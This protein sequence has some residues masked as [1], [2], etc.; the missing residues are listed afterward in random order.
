MAAR[1]RMA[2]AP[3]RARTRPRSTARPPMPRATSPRTSSPPTSPT[4]APS[5]SPTRSASPSRCRSMSTCTAPA[6]SRRAGS[7]RRSSDV[8]DLSPRGIREHLG[9]NRPIYARTSA[10]GHFGRAPEAD[11]GFSWEK[12]DL[13]DDAPR[14][15]ALI[16]GYPPSERGARPWRRSTAEPARPAEGQAPFGATRPALMADRLA[17]ARARHRRAAASDLSRRSFRFRSRTC[18]SR[19]ASAAA[20]ISSPRRSAAPDTGFI[21]VEPF[22][23]RHGEGG[24]RRSTT[25]DSGTSASTTATPCSSS[26]GCRPPRSPASTSSIPTRGRSGAT[27]S[28][29]SSARRTSTASRGC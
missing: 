7:R 20:S 9:L 15:G 10:Y 25:A 24:G 12:T 5:S 27:G 23:E 1:P 16:A 19:S 21:G 6:R 13:V 29:A 18:G 26:T 14:R 28:A 2:A 8:M 4:A 22:I 3:S 11:G 17:G